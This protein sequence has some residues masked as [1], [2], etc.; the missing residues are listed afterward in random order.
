MKMEKKMWMNE[1]QFPETSYH[2]RLTKHEENWILY[3][4]VF[5][6]YKENYFLSEKYFPI[7]IIF[8]YKNN[9]LISY[10]L[11]MKKKFLKRIC[12]FNPTFIENV[13]KKE[14]EIK[15]LKKKQLW[16]LYLCKRLNEGMWKVNSMKILIKMMEKYSFIWSLTLNYA[17]NI[18]FQ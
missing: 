10:F 1:K 15:S 18:W 2:T 8:I 9:I 3:G 14:M 13:S 11:F 16:K 12:D 5:I 17:N 7:F 4:V 6:F